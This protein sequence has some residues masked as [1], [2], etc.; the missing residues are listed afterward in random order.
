MTYAFILSYLIFRNHV[1]SPYFSYFHTKE[2][3]TDD[4][5]IPQGKATRTTY[6]SGEDSIEDPCIP[7]HFNPELLILL[8][9]GQPL[10]PTIAN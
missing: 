2:D 10:H 6:G 5:G 3:K 7:P 1:L 4:D 9:S 8:L